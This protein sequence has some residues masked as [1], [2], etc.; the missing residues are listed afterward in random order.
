MPT[1]TPRSSWGWRPIACGTK[2]GRALSASFTGRGLHGVKPCSQFTLRASRA[3]ATRPAKPLFFAK[4]RKPITGSDPAK[5]RTHA[6]TVLLWTSNPA[7]Q[8][9]KT[10][11][12]RLPQNP[13]ARRDIAGRSQSARRAPR[14]PRTTRWRWATGSGTRD[15]SARLT[16]GLGAPVQIRRKAVRGA[17]AIL[18]RTQPHFH[19][20]GCRPNSGMTAD[21]F[22]APLGFLRRWRWFLLRGARQVREPGR[23]L[24]MDCCLRIN[25]VIADGAAFPQRIHDGGVSV[26]G[27]HQSLRVSEQSW[28]TRARARPS[29]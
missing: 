23:A 13:L 19:G 25:G 6:T 1:P 8:A 22:T 26:V 16:R 29:P 20:F 2:P 27:E 18:A 17:E 5:T 7:Q 12:D 14:L 10:S 11:I 15:V 4:P 9:C 21:T 28:Q 3:K 24:G